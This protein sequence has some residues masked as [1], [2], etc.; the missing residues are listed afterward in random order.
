MIPL[1]ER[2]RRKRIDVALQ[3]KIDYNKESMLGITKNIS[4]L[5]TYAYTD[6]SIPKGI[7]LNI[8]VKIPQKHLARSSK[9]IWIHSQA[10]AFRSKKSISPQGK[11]QYGIGIFFRSFSKGSEETLSD[12]IDYVILK[13]KEAGKVFMRKRKEKLTKRKGGKE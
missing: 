7:D 13:E 10:V 8:G 5:G 6:K 3:L 2:R 4:L 9:E 11:S 12:Y 1:Q